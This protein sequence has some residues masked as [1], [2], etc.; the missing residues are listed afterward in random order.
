MIDVQR[1]VLIAAIAALSFM[2]LVE[3]NQ[4]QQRAAQLPASS[5][6]LTEQPF[7][8]VSGEAT[9]FPADRPAATAQTDADDIPVSTAPVAAAPAA[10][11]DRLI[12]VRTDNLVIKISPVGGDIVHAALPKHFAR[13]DTP[14]AP[15]VLLENNERRQFV[16]QSGLV[17]PNGTDKS[18]GRPRFTSSS[19]RY[20][21]ADGKDELVVDLHYQQSE[22][23]SITKRYRFRRGAYLINLEYIV[24]NRGSEPW[25]GTLFGQF[26]RD[27]SPDPTTET[28]GNAMGM[29][30]FLGIAWTD[31]ESP[32]QKMTF[33]K[34]KEKP[35]DATVESGWIAL[36]QHYFVS[37]WIPARDQTNHYSSVVTRRGDNIAR[38]T[39][40]PVTVPAGSS[41]TISSDLYIGPKD[42]YRLEGIY[43]GLDLTVD[44]SFL[45]WIAQPLFWLLFQL[46]KLLGNWGW[47]IV[48]V[49]LLVKI[50]F[51][52]LNA[53]A[54]RSMA[55]MRKVQPQMLAIREQ[56]AEDRQKQSQAMME[57]Y[58]KE[59]VNPMGSCLPMLL[60]MP[61]FI[62]LYWVLMESV[63][64]RHAPWILWI[65]DLS[66]QDP[67]YVLPLIMGASMFVQQKLN[68]PPPD[69]MQAK[70][71]QWL[72][73]VF[74]AF[75]LFFPAGLVLYWVV[76]NLL[77]IIQQYIITKHI[78][79]GKG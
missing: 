21:L 58:K 15:F 6:A 45:W 67:Y 33:K 46:H 49:T 7:D 48:G 13:I 51:F 16:A 2:L 31:A 20:A 57:L 68:P 5:N 71:M 28:G 1:Y 56:Y 76:N 77:S 36:V 24:D 30:P 34:M 27:N 18:S 50:A 64:L 52:H 39:A 25:Q 29:T 23:V 53:T 12:S 65:Q 40:P 66:A 38:F 32:Y 79:S 10:T 61:V 17:G 69:P 72:P 35:L 26:K 60:Q 9:A 59:K 47:A 75:F 41:A 22:Q 55:K 37:A 19:N 8:A 78:E 74:T 4:F 11:G 63:E 62:A 73:V 42:Q 43:P 54:F 3:W 14:D 70:I 44:Y